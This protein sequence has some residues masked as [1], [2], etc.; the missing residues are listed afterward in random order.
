MANTKT[1]FAGVTLLVASAALIGYGRQSD[2]FE[3][4]ARKSPTSVFHKSSPSMKRTKAVAPK[5]MQ[6]VKR[7]AGDDITLYGV[8]SADYEYTLSSFP[9]TEGTEF[10]TIISDFRME[11][12]GGAVYFDG[13]L[14]VN[15]VED[16]GWGDAEA[17]QYIFDPATGKRTG[18]RDI[19]VQSCATVMA[20]NSL[21]DNVYGQFYDSELNELYWG[22]WNPDTGEATHIAHM[23][24]RLY[25]LAFD[26]DGTAYAINDNG[27][28]ET[29]NTET[30]AAVNKI[31]N[32]G[33]L[34][35]YLQ[36]G[37]IDVASGRMFWAPYTEN[38]NA[39]GLYEVNKETAAITKISD[40]EDEYTEIAYMY[41]IAPKADNAAPAA[42]GDLT[43]NFDGG[44]LSGTVSFTAPSLT[45][46]GE[47]L[48]GDLEAVIE[49]DEQPQTVSTQ[50]GAA[51]EVPVSVSEAG[52]HK[53]SVYLTK[54]GKR[55]PRATQSKWI[56]IDTPSAVGNLTLTKE[57][58]TAVLTWDAPTLGTHGGYVDADALTYTI[59]RSGA[60]QIT[61]YT[62]TTYTEEFADG[63]N[64][65]IQYT[66]TPYCGSLRGPGTVSNTVLFT[67]VAEVP[68][69]YNF[70]TPGNT[71]LFSTLDANEDGVA[72]EWFYG[73]YFRYDASAD[74]VGAADDWV[75]SPE[76]RLESGRLYYVT[77]N[78]APRNGEFYPETF[79]IKAGNSV[80]PEGQTISVAADQSLTGMRV[81]DG[82][83]DYRYSFSVP[84]EGNYFIG[85][86]LTSPAGWTQTAL[87]SIG[88]EAGEN[89]SAPAAPEDVTAVAGAEGAL[90]ADITFTA[91]SS[92]I[93]GFRLRLISRIDVTNEAGEVVGT[94]S[95]PTA[96]FPC[97]VNVPAVQGNNTFT[98][99]AYD[100]NGD[101]GLPATVSVFCGEHVPADPTDVHLTFDAET[102]TSLLSWTAPTQGADGGYFNPANLRFAIYNSIYE[103]FIDNDI[104][105]TSWSRKESIPANEQE[106]LF[107]GVFAYNIAGSSYGTVSNTLLV[108]NDYTLPFFES[109]PG[110][111]LRYNMWIMEQ[112]ETNNEFW[113]VLQ[114]QGHLTPD[115]CSY[116]MAA[117][118]GEQVLASGKIDLSDATNPVVTFWTKPAANNAD[119]IAVVVCTEYG[120]PYA[121]VKRF[122]MSDFEAGE[123]GWAKITCSLKDYA[124]MQHVQ[125]GFKGISA[126]GNGVYL[127]DITVRDLADNDLL[128]GTLT[129]TPTTAIAAT[130][131]VTASFT[132]ENQGAKTVAGTDYS[133]EFYKGDE[134]FATLNGKE[135]ASETTQLFSASFVP[136]KDDAANLAIKAVINFAADAHPE[137]N[138][139][140]VQHLKVTRPELPVVEDLAGTIENGA[141]SLTWSTPNIEELPARGITESFE[142]YEPF[143]ISDMGEW[144]LYDAD[145]AETGGLASRYFPHMYAPKAYQVIDQALITPPMD[146]WKPRTGKQ[147]ITTL[148]SETC[149]NDDWLIS[150]RLS[151]REQTINFFAQSVVPDY[152]LE[153]FEIWY[154]YDSTD[155]DDFMLLEDGQQA[156]AYEWTEFNYTLPE[157]ARYFAI[158]CV[159]DNK[160]CF[161]LDDITYEHAPVKLDLEHRGFALYRDG[162]KIADLGPEVNTYIDTQA[163]DGDHIYSVRV[164]YDKGESNDSNLFDTATVG[165]DDV[166][167]T[168]LP[169]DW[170]T[171]AGVKVPATYRGI[172]VAKGRK[173]ITK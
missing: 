104:T 32:T 56:G 36:S 124:G 161:M 91:P 151:G 84:S 18:S 11:A 106:L 100:F 14:Y 52:T 27:L 103:D 35:R 145:G 24:E 4:Y 125:V 157:G 21:T 159:S 168:D 85:L 122:K 105:E 156:P 109:F 37:T 142:D 158:R 132:V 66:V 173:I 133:V 149:A 47:E 71:A 169:A 10:S 40:F 153:D 63:D 130:T 1:Y 70:T 148:V 107:Y 96:G 25:V 6:R 99:R 22:K 93:N 34:P 116:F 67:S 144:T 31:G 17:T 90:N 13:L 128:A 15:N 51:V 97:T 78:M 64:A 68:W 135:I 49:V 30:G 172:H 146:V 114:N 111:G 42:V 163:G 72:W 147:F 95:M 80:T 65:S 115:G 129:L 92:C 82:Y 60:E 5:G 81:I 98:L 26:A 140:E 45:Y 118:G 119:E 38:D 138:T 141:V 102:S 127:D 89:L 155:P 121:E 126:G 69:Y 86:H 77:Y 94:V 166:E 131:E 53:F 152:G 139:S 87:S 164:V 29:L 160:M 41:T 136:A 134:I 20:V 48:T 74:G 8:V 12:T 162:E 58:N 28:L 123:D 154:S 43:V 33:I 76:T 9:V 59:A 54:D 150:P 108:G 7:M 2:N 39:L 120:Q 110:G 62:S 50:A 88:I 137:D 113:T 3:G 46:G 57:G 44:A 83:K 19:L 23:S 167:A 61:G 143:T 117:P 171:P 79:E 101:M 75:F 16:T 170:Y 73:G 165:L 55:G 112:G